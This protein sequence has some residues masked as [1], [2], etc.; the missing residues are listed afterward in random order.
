MYI[1]IYIYIYVCMYV[2][3]YVCVYIYIYMLYWKIED[4]ESRYNRTNVFVRLFKV[5]WMRMGCKIWV[6]QFFS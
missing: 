2:C 5:Q 3:M 1:Y 4:R 6:L